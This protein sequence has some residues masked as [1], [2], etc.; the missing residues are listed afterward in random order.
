MNETENKTPAPVPVAAA[1]APEK[2]KA[3][4]PGFFAKAGGFIRDCRTECGKIT[5]PQRKEL[6]DSTWVV[7]AMILLLSVFVFVCDQVLLALLC[8][9]VGD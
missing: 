5:W 9:V 1:P 4:E 6:M 7:G 8:W 3:A 2:A